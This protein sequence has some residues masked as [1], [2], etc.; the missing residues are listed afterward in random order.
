M[1]DQTRILRQGPGAEPRS[2][3]SE[4]GIPLF[5]W[6]PETVEPQDLFEAW[7]DVVRPLSDTTPVHDARSFVGGGTFAKMGELIVTEVDFTPQCLTRTRA[8]I[9][10]TDMFSLQFYR[11]GGSSRTIGD[12]PYRTVPDRIALFDLAREY[13][14]LSTEASVVLGASIP[15]EQLDTAAIGERPAVAWS[16]DS[17][18]GRLL[19]GALTIMRENIERLSQA[20]A[21]GAAAGFIG[22]L[23]GLLGSRRESADPQPIRHLCQ[24][25][26]ERFIEE[27]LRRPDLDAAVLC[28]TFGSSRSRL[29]DLFKDHGGVERYIRERRL[30]RCFRDLV[31]AEPTSTRVGKV[32]AHWGFHDQ[33]HF[34]RLF[35]QQFA[36]RPSD[37]LASRPHGASDGGNPA[38]LT[39]GLATAHQWFRAL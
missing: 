14:A 19:I 32:A 9:A 30:A 6:G 13:R 5:R 33:S 21:A 24:A 1:A 15:R 31:A 38:K 26:I 10:H 16:R 25:T 17:V 23:N 20:E 36:M 11:R 4:G 27:N 39:Q 35:K 8:H 37:V 18:A 22:L 7:H 28:R 34:N 12:V 29:Y 2:P 3:A